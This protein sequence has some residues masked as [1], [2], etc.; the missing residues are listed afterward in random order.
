MPQSENSNKDCQVRSYLRRPDRAF[1]LDLFSPPPTPTEA[2]HIRRSR[3][4][5][6]AL[7]AAVLVT[8]FYF[9]ISLVVPLKDGFTLVMVNVVS[10]AC[11]GMGIWA[12]SLQ[13]ERIAR[14]WLMVTVNTEIAVFIALTGTTFGVGV[15][16][17]TNAVLARVLFEPHE[18]V[19]RYF[20]IGLPIVMLILGMAFATQSYIDFSGVSPV[21]LSLMSMINNIINLLCVLLILGV[22]DREVLKTEASLVQERARSDRLLHAIL[23]QK[24]A[25]QLRH[26]DRMIA[27]RHPEVTVL[28][29]DVAGFTPWSSRQEPEDVVSLLEK[30]FSR[31]DAR[32]S[33]LGAEK[34]KTI[35]DAYMVVSGAPDPRQDHAHVIAHLALALLEEIQIIRQETGIALDMRIGVHT[36]SVIAGV[37]GAVRFSYDI[38]GDTVNTAS[39]MESHGEAGRIQISQQTKDC[40]ADAFIVEPRGMIDVKGKGEMATWWLIAPK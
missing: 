32:L 26:N 39:R 12:A 16:C 21:L 27:D 8:V 10:L 37:I 5:R 3:I 29:A 13:A 6:Y 11:Y 28:F 14:L 40:I 15:F 30:I 31:F 1:W 23:P 33:N 9:C 18:K 34:I 20:F 7:G 36:G 2:D 17:M 38:W 35:G 4:T 24:I 19:V 25:N 22:F